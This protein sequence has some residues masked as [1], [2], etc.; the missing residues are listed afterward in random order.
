MP[1]GYGDD[2]SHRDHPRTIDERRLMEVLARHLR[3]E[4]SQSLSRIQRRTGFNRKQ[5]KEVLGES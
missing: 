3:Y 2:G 5:L 1:D 4:H